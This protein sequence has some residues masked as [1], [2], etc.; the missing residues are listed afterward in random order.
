MGLVRM[1][2]I[3]YSHGL[4]PNQ[5]QGGLCIVGTLLVLRRSRATRTHKTHHSL[6]LGEATAFPLIVYFV[7]L[8]DTHIKMA[9][10]FGIPKWESRNCQNWDSHDFGAHNFVCKPPIKMR[11]NAKL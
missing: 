5:T 7:P 9:F 3:N 11:F 6:G 10:F 1:T 4:A 2:S 8:H